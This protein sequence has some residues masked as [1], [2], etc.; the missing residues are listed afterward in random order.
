MSY[1]FGIDVGGTFTDFSFFETDTQRLNHY[2]LSSTPDDPS[3]AIIEGIQEIM[4]LHDIDPGRI[5]YLAHGTTVATNALIQKKGG[6]TALITTKGFKDLLEISRQTRPSLYDSTQEKPSPIVRGKYLCEVDERILYDGEVRRE[7]DVENVEAVVDF[8]KAEGVDGIA[9]CTLFSYVNP[10]HER[11]IEQVIHER[12]PGAFVSVSHRITPEFREVPRMSTTVVNAFLGPVMKTYVNNFQR[13]VRS[14]DIATQPYIT[15]SNGSIISI[16]ETVEAPVRTALSG[17]SSGVVAAQYVARLCGVEQIITFDMGGTSADICLLSKDAPSFASEKEIEGY[18]VRI[19]MIDIKTIGAGGGSI[20]HIDDGGALK[21]GP[22]SAG[23]VP[24]P[25]AYMRGGTKPTLTDAN[26]LLG[27]LN[28]EKLL[29]GRMSIDASLAKLAIEREICAKTGLDVLEAAKGIVSVINANMVRIARVVSVERGFDIREFALVAFGG[30]GPL[31]AC[32]IA[33]ELGV[34]RIIIPSSPGTFC[35]LGLLVADVKYDYVKTN[36]VKASPENLDA[37]NRVFEELEREGEAFLANER[38]PAQSRRYIRRIDA[39]YRM[40][41]YELTVPASDEKLDEASLADI[42]RTFH[43]E[44]EKNY[45]HC[46]RTQEIELVNF[47]LS[48]IG[49]RDKPA[50]TRSN[51][52]AHRLAPKARREVY[53]TRE[54][55]QDCPIYD[56]DS[57]PLRAV[58]RGPA[59]VEQMDTT[60]VIAPCWRCEIDEWGNIVMHSEDS[61]GNAI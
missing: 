56:K 60:V 33:E 26:I 43:E 5:S 8:L 17:P 44:H 29:S 13:A 45:G 7:L 41:N 6:K 25:A 15:Q 9:V 47:R 36:I 23:A 4:K 28:P 37:I 27:R 48:A 46:D 54:G 52:A 59:V 30:A 55:F 34:R 32:D 14:L 20:A 39:R 42:C 57:L 11:R 61:E 50:L 58:F 31:H 22:E 1:W 53:F 12:F 51:R 16:S 2:K 21:V 24:G 3:R 10:E 18:T 35:S 38:V 49:L 40:Q 19:P